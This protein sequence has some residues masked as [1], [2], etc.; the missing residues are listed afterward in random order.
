MS[1][2]HHDW[3]IRDMQANEIGMLQKEKNVMALLL[4]EKIE[5]IARLRAALH[6]IVESSLDPVSVAIA[7]ETLATTDYPRKFK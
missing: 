1:P 2:N 6:R 3:E 7:H 4:D 5:D